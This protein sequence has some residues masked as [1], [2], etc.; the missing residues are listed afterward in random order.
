MRLPT[1]TRL[2]WGVALLALM[3]VPVTAD[4][5]YSGTDHWSTA[6]T[7][8]NFKEDPI[9]A[10][11]FCPGSAS[12]SGQIDLKGMPLTTEPECILG[13][14]DT[15]VHRLDNATFNEDGSA[16]TRLRFLAI[17]LAGVE[18]LEVPGCGLYDV[19]A[20]LDGG[21]QPTTEMKIYRKTED[22]GTFVAPL[23]LNVRM[24]FTPRAGGEPVA[25]RREIYLGPGTSSVWSL[26]PMAKEIIHVKV[27][28]DGDQVVDTML[29]A[30][31][32]FAAGNIDPNIALAAVTA[33]ARCYPTNPDPITCPEGQ[34][35]RQSCH[36]TPW[37]QNPDPDEG[38]ENCVGYPDNIS[39]CHLHCVNT[40]VA[41]PIEEEPHETL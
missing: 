21:K 23:K 7:Y 30:P 24:R 5:I 28:T 16:T 13:S 37:S 27:D 38:L 15:I 10:D 18:P 8:T 33:I 31:S 19:T 14:I 4:V 9:P 39:V 2:V 12:F 41:C 20:S 3:A 25:V 26:V 36:C 40:C 32:N 34:C 29:P 1:S 11:F 6:Q 17:S 22:G 35:P